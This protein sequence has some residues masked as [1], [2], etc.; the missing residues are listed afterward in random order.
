MAPKP[1]STTGGKG[2]A[3]GTASKQPAKTVEGAKGAKKTAKTAAPPAAGEEKKKRRKGRKETYSSYIYKVLKQI[4]PEIGI[5]N[6]AM[7]ILNS[8]VNDIFERI[9][10]EASSMRV[11]VHFVWRLI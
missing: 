2:P 9:A 8:F 6:K 1:A 3:S 7:S 10:T 4:H 5:A 11:H